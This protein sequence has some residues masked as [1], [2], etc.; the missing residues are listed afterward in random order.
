[1]LEFY[2]DFM[3][4]F[5]DRSDWDYCEMDTDSA[6]IAVPHPDWESL[7]KPA[8]REAY[9]TEHDQWLPRRDHYEFDKRTPGL[10]EE[11]WSG[12]EMSSLCSKT[13]YCSGAGG[14]KL[15]CKG[16]SRTNITMAMYCDFLHTQK[17]ALGSNRGMRLFPREHEMRSYSLQK[18]ALTYFYGKRKV[19]HDGIS[20]TFL[21]I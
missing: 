18:T 7:V 9:E 3:D 10:F 12:K 21:D 14:E 5:F 19:L 8:Q 13:Y 6:Y 15:S 11:E 17:S 1:M 20:S 4:K 2:Y 16:G